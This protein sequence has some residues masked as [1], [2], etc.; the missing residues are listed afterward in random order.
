[1]PTM[2]LLKTFA[3]THSMPNQ[4]IVTQFYL[5]DPARIMLKCLQKEHAKPLACRA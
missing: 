4:I 2:C 5:L 3:D 1:M